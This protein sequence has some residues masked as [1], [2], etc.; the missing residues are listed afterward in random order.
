[1]GLTFGVACLVRFSNVVLIAVPLVAAWTTRSTVPPSGRR[2][3]VSSA[4]RRVGPI[5]VVHWR[6]PFTSSC[7]IARK[8]SRTANPLPCAPS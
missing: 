4:F 3:T 2:A 1:M 5:V 6:G 7:A 8:F